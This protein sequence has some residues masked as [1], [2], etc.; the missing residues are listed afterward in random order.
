MRSLLR[1]I[2]PALILVGVLMLLVACNSESN[3]T[4]QQPTTSQSA[5]VEADT[6]TSGQ[7]PEATESMTEQADPTS[8]GQ[9]PKAT[10]PI[11][12]QSDPATPSQQT[13]SS[14]E[15]SSP[16][17]TAAE[18]TTSAQPAPKLDVVTTTNILADWAHAVGQDRVS[19]A[20]LLP[21]NADPHTFQ[22]GARDVAQVADAGLVLTVGLSLEA[23]WLDDLVRNA[24]GDPE[25]IIALGDGVDPIDFEEI[26]E[27]HDEEEM[28]EILGRL[29]I[30]DGVT[31]AM[32]VIDL[33]HGDVEQD[34]FD[35]GERAGRI[36]ATKSGRFA[37]AVSSDA[38]NV[39]VIDGGI[40]LD[41]HGDH[42]DLVEA[43]PRQMGIDLAGDR[44]VHLYVGGEWAVIFYDGSGDVVL[45]NEH[46]L[47]EEGSDYVPPRFNVGPQHGA[48]VPLEGDLLATSIKHPDYPANPDARRPIGADIRDME[49]NVLYSAEGC[50]DLHGDASNGH[51]AAFGCTG[52]ALVVEAHDG[53]YGHVFVPAPDGEPEDFRLTSVWGYPGLDHFFAL[54]SEVGLYIVDPEEGSMEQ[55]IPASEDLRPIQVAFGY[56]GEALLVVMSDGEL[57]MYDAHDL[58]LLASASGFLATPVETGFW[59]R[60]H[61]ATAVGAVFVTDSVGG[62]VF[63]LDDDDLEVVE[64]WEVDGAPTKIAFVGVL[65][66]SEGHEEHGHEEEGDDGHGHGAL[67]PHFW[68]DPLRVQQAVNSIAAQLSTI[69]PEG[70]VSYRE[71]AAAYSRELEQLHT[72]IEEQVATLPEERR[73]LV[74]SHD[75]FQYFAKRYGFEVVGAIF[76]ISTESEPTAQELAELIETIE[77]A[78]AP[79]V[80][81]EKSH[82]AR[83]GQRV[84]EETGATLIGG[85]YTGSLS[86]PGGEADTYIDLM[87]YNVETIVEALE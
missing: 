5:T 30:G 81:A 61:I 70:Q 71:N 10:E 25:K 39:N 83:L 47:E 54:G 36:Y 13:K 49:G 62:K 53:E 57:R 63:Q 87:R 4:S 14:M 84:A 18:S 67:D 41:G 26:F 12:A 74:T 55:F 28:E 3:T 43:P 79:A 69:D 19:V 56:G 80:F 77:H 40:F 48:A 31:G 68:F 38:D 6:S 50:P 15:S 42:F 33:E 46:E 16:T 9:Q 60:P 65:G 37:I 73:L 35:L 76:P 21:P 64:Q 29:L 32:S 20:S 7:Q 78:G 24:A 52:G 45:I 85:L 75:S 17:T 82:S 44:P 1:N 2:T 72:W 8:P 58:D 27:D 51:Q 86:E 23:G 11:V 59:A 22:P 66:E 34:A